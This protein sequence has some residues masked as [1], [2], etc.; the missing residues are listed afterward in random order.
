ME[1]KYIYEVLVS[2]VIDGDTFASKEI[3]LGMG[4]TLKGDIR[5]RLLG[6]DTP[7]RREEG[8][9]EA[10]E[11]TSDKIEGKKVLV[12]TVEKDNFG[13]WLC[14]V[15]LE[16]NTLNNQLLENKLAVIYKK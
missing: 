8:Y 12:E 10:T 16:D 11:F 6:V 9:N 5:F 3:D 1:R 7:E 14:I 2:R 15:H 4:V 13:R